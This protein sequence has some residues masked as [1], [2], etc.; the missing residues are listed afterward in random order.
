M[1]F[2]LELEYNREAVPFIVLTRP[3]Q[4]S[5]LNAKSF[6]SSQN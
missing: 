6:P 4:L 1:R 2:H 5:F 3:N